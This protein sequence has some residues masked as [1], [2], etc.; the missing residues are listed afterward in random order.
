MYTICRFVVRGMLPSKN[1]FAWGGWSVC[2]FACVKCCGG[3]STVG[4]GFWFAM[5]VIIR[6]KKRRE[7]ARH[8][9]HGRDGM[10]ARGALSVRDEAEVAGLHF[11]I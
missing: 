10:L 4:A 1:V 7:W 3:R 6:M 11:R 2:L 9:G 5:T 8:L